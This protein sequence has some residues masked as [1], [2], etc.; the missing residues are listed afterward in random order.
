M[1][2]AEQCGMSTSYIGD[3]EQGT[4]NDSLAMMWPCATARLGP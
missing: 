3:V 4:V 2:L 1:E